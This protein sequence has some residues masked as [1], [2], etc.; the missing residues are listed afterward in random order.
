M[1]I[2][3]KDIELSVQEAKELYQELDVLFGS[4]KHVWPPSIKDRI[5]GPWPTDEY[6]R[7]V[8]EPIITCISNKHS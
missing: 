7:P 5:Y 4:K 6:G 2:V 3:V 8:W 1:K